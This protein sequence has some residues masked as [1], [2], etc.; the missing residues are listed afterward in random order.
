MAAKALSIKSVAV[1]GSLLASHYPAVTNARDIP[2]NLQHF[3]DTVKGKTCSN[4]IKDGFHDGHGNSGWSYCG[5]YKDN[6]LIYLAGPSRKQSLGDMDV[7]CDGDDRTAGKCSNDNSGQDQTTF[8]QIVKGYGFSDLNANIHGYVVFGNEGAKPSFE[9]KE[10]GMKPLSIMA[11]ICNN[12]LFYGIWGDTNGGTDTGEASISL[13][14]ACFPD[15]NITGDNG[16]TDHDVLYLGFTGPKAVP[17]KCGANWKAESFREFEESLAHIGD[18]LVLK[19]PGDPSDGPVSTGNK[20]QRA[21]N[22]LSL[23][24]LLV[25]QRILRLLLLSV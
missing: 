17:G 6:G 13:A 3:Y 22:L 5:D 25:L 24:V 15:G 19:V 16:H 11:V 14:T 20:S 18:S 8:Q 1:L 2:P 12:Q 23:P 10:A 21:P 4:P 7:D 9:P